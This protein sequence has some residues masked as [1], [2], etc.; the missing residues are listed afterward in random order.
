MARTSIE[1]SGLTAA[2]LIARRTGFSENAVVGMLIMLW[3]DSQAL[4]RTEASRARLI[5]WLN[6]GSDQ[7]S[8]EVD[9]LIESLED[10]GI[11]VQRDEGTWL[12]V[13]NDKHIENLRQRKDDA[14]A[15]GIASGRARQRTVERTVEQP[16]NGPLNA[17]GTSVEPNTVQC[18]AV[19]FSAVQNNSKEKSRAS[20][21]FDFESIYQEYPRKLGKAKG[22]KIAEREIKT[23]A[24]F[25]RLLIAVKRY[26]GHVRRENVEA[27]YVKHF[28]TFMGSWQDWLDD[29]VGKFKPAQPPRPAPRIEPSKPEDYGPPDE[30]SLKIIRGLIGQTFKSMPT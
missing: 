27:N 19:Q 1:E 23:E 28:S 30:E 12:I 29:D 4:E 22:L 14:K 18:S 5:E 24:D 13:G 25:D 2:R 10:N 17:R 11:L 7:Q 6:I 3:H 26:A 16:V 21:S 15:A 9:Q 20:R 8:D